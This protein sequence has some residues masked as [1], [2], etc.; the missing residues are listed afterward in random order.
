MDRS[1]FLPMTQVVLK[2]SPQDQPGKILTESLA[3]VK[4]R[5]LLATMDKRGVVGRTDQL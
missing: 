2:K 1:T 5:V 3:N 4:M